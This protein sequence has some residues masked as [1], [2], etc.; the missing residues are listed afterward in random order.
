MPIEAI[1][2][3]QRPVPFT[4]C[5]KCGASPF[6]PFMRG[7][8][9]SRWRHLFRRLCWCLIC[10]SCKQIVGYEEELTAQEKETHAC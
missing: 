8:V 4:S 1:A 6:Q 5:P 7:Q 3:T 2:F 9:I 10:S